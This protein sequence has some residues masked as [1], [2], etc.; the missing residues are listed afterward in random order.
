M[1]DKAKEV[2][3]S[4]ELGALM[5]MINNEKAIEAILDEEYN[6]ICY[7]D[8]RFEYQIEVINPQYITKLNDK[9]EISNVSDQE[10]LLNCY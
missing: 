1:Y 5:D 8:E 9:T 10:I 7:Y 4:L 6:N 3:A 2:S